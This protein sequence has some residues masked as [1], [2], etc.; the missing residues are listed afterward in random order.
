MTRISIIIPCYYNELNLPI[1]SKRLVENESHFPSDLAFEYVMV[2]DGSKDNTYIELKKFQEAYPEK[3]TV[4][5]LA[6]NVGSYNAILAGMAH[7]TGDCNVV[8][9]AD[10]QDPPE[11]IAQMYGHWQNGYKLV[12]A[13]RTNRDDPWLSKILANTFQRLIKKYGL[14]NLPEGGFDFVF[15]DKKLKE[16]VIAIKEKNTNI[17]YLLLWLGY[18]Y[19]NIPYKR[20]ERKIGKSRWTFSKKLKLFIDSFIA[21]SFLPIRLI[22][23]M[24]LF[25]GWVSFLYAILIII[26]RITGKI[27]FVQGWTSMMVVQL[28]VA[29]FQ[30][31]ALGIIGEYIWRTLDSVRNRPIYVE[32]KIIKRKEM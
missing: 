6:K 20:E 32:D 10:L 27:P 28:F 31:L 8:I 29:S 26:G 3:V 12:I 25:L 14:T 22:T 23:G 2:D 5:K 24:G 15:F 17:L 13:N 21:F 11:I 9:A 7:A 16:E 1:T 19:V 18:E 30:F 4:V